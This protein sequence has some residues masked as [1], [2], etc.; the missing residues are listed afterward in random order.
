M[1][2]VNKTYLLTLQKTPT[3]KKKPEGEGRGQ[4]SA[5]AMKLATAK[6]AA[7]AWW[8]GLGFRV[9]EFQVRNPIPLHEDCCW[10]NHT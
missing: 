6:A 9:G 8:Q 5:D 1:G 4:W 7:V 3:F 10:L 2:Y